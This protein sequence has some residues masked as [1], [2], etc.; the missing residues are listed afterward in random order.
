[1]SP[2][3]GLGKLSP[4]AFGWCFLISLRTVRVKWCWFGCSR[5]R[6][7]VTKLSVYNYFIINVLVVLCTQLLFPILV[8][9]IELFTSISSRMPSSSHRM[10]CYRKRQLLQRLLVFSLNLKKVQPTVGT[11]DALCTLLI[12]SVIITLQYIPAIRGHSSVT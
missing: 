2:A 7:F 6:R 1:M 11:N 12:H 4:L 9:M 8:V 5:C 3:N 10:G